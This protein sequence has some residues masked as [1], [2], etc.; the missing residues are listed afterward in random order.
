MSFFGNIVDN[1]IGNVKNK[2]A[3]AINTT[4]SGLKAAKQSFVAAGKEFGDQLTRIAG[5]DN[6]LIDSPLKT[7]GNVAQVA[8]ALPLSAWKGAT[9]AATDVALSQ[10]SVYTPDLIEKPIKSAVAGT[11][12]AVASTKVAQDIGDTIQEFKT[13]HPS[14]AFY[15]FNA[16]DPITTITPAGTVK[17]TIGKAVAGA[18]VSSLAAKEFATKFPKIFIRATEL[19][20]KVRGGSKLAAS[21]ADELID[22]S[23]KT[24]LFGENRLIAFDGVQQLKDAGVK[25][26][27]PLEEKMADFA[28]KIRYDGDASNLEAKIASYPKSVQVKE[29]L[30]HRYEPINYAESQILKDANVPLDGI[31]MGDKFQLSASFRGQADNARNQFINTIKKKVGSRKDYE[32]LTEYMVLQRIKSLFDQFP[33]RKMA[34]WVK[35]EAESVIKLMESKMGEATTFRYQEIMRDVTKQANSMVL[36]AYKGGLMDEDTFKE[37]VARNGQHFYLPQNT[38]RHADD[39]IDDNLFL[40]HIQGF[41]DEAFEIRDPI[42]QLAD[43]TAQTKVKALKNKT[44]QELESL[45]KLDTKERFLMIATE[46]KPAPRSW[47]KVSIK[48]DGKEIGMYAEPTLAKSITGMNAQ[49]VGLVTKLLSPTKKILSTGATGFN[50]GFQAVSVPYNI[51]RLAK[52]SK[53]GIHSAK[54]LIT[55]TQDIGNG[56][57]TALIGNLD[58]QHPLAVNY[59]RSYEAFLSSGAA[60]STIQKALTPSIAKK[61]VYQNTAYTL[62]QTPAKLTA[63]LEETTKIASLSRG[64]REVNKK[65]GVNNDR[66]NSVLYH[67]NPQYKNLVQDVELET[68]R[69]GGSPDFLQSGTATTELNHIFMF[70]NAALQ[71]NASDFV[72]YT[73]DLTTPAG[74]AAATR[75]AILQSAVLANQLRNHLYYQE[76]LEKVSSDERANYF[77]IFQDKYFINDSGERVREAYRIPKRESMKVV[78]NLVEGIL[79]G[80]YK[81]DPTSMQ[82]IALQFFED[83]SPLRLDLSP[84]DGQNIVQSSLQSLTSSVNP[85]LKTPIEVG[86]N[87]NTFNNRAIET[88]AMKALEPKDRYTSDTPEYLKKIGAGVSKLGLDSTDVLE[89]PVMLEHILNSTTGGF[90][91]SISGGKGPEGRSWAASSP[92]LKRFFRSQYVDSTSQWNTIAG[93]EGKKKGETTANYEWAEKKVAEIKNA[94]TKMEKLAVIEGLAEMEKNGE[95]DSKKIKAFTNV[96]NDDL[97]GITPIER[98]LRTY[99]NSGT[100]KDGTFA[101]NFYYEFLP[102]EVKTPKEAVERIMDLRQKEVISDKIVEQLLIIIEADGWKR[103]SQSK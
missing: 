18:Y 11:V 103:L 21:E 69:Y 33:D 86:F 5:D 73:K 65:F 17:K 95:I 16:L 20:S 23:L 32:Q 14:A 12:G 81:Q 55:F 94:T 50:I 72:R 78:G 56:L 41:E 31:K 24:P 88:D 6:S 53:F 46:D 29:T 101:K 64:M 22:I 37:I 83:M 80:I 1:A 74:K 79:E 10:A 99:A 45:A 84:K 102:T 7:V 92:I 3:N 9:N 90:F 82:Q 28:K 8:V 67:N 43:M 40:K 15:T 34:G 85:L 68:R 35:G 30:L 70:F 87:M 76:D 93:W 100:V 19:I 39:S 51:L 58:I 44:L 2:T 25:V 38:L 36:D 61:S 57:A 4:I 52:E 27:H 48:K 96:L 89:S 97:K 66:I 47:I 63:A 98:K 26:V 77:M 62:L 49:Q 71:G 91:K 13:K 54:D 42:A 75:M 60:N 59:R